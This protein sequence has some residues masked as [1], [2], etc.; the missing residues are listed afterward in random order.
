MQREPHRR[1]GRRP[2]LIVVGI[3]AVMGATMSFLLFGRWT[4]LTEAGT[5]GAE[6]MLDEAVAAAG[7]GTPYIEIVADGA[8]VVHREQ[9]GIRPPG[10][11]SLVL[12][13]WLPTEGRVLRIEYPHWFVRLKTMST[14]NLGTMIAASRRDWAHLGLSID[15]DDLSR[16]GPGLL[17]DNRGA[18]GTRL[19]LWVE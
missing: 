1:P 2:L 10:F 16:R 13:A 12:M 7:G 6:R 15:Y 17:L 19:L 5:T 9:E 14:F 11:G 3:L 8:V 4:S 18:D